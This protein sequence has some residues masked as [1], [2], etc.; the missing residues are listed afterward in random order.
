MQTLL[1][2]QNDSLLKLVDLSEDNRLAQLNSLSEIEK[3][4][5]QN[6]D[7]SEEV[8]KVLS[9][10]NDSIKNGFEK[11]KLA[12]N[13]AKLAKTMEK[14][15]SKESVNKITEAATGRREY[16][17][18]GERIRD[19]VM[20]RDGDK[21]DKDSLR[22]KFT[23][24]KGFAD[25]AGIVKAGSTGLFGDML[26]KREEKQKYIENAI[27]LNPQQK[28]LAQYGGDE[29]KV[30]EYYGKQ[31][32]EVKIGEK[33]LSS[34]QREID[35][36]KQGGLS[37]EE[38]QRTTGGKKLLKEKAS[39]A[40][41]LGK[42]DFRFKGLSKKEEADGADETVKS[43]NVFP[44]SS[45]KDIS[46][47]EAQNENARA[48][49]EQTELLYQ[50]EEN[51]RPSEVKV[52]KQKKDKGDGFNFSPIGL[53]GSALAVT[54]GGIVGAIQGQLKAIKFFTKLLTPT[55]L[56]E[57][58]NKS[59]LNIT[60]KVSKS[61][62]S[63]VAGLSM[64]FDL[65]KAGFVEKMKTF[66][67]TFDDVFNSVKKFFSFSEDS[68]MFKIFST[69]KST[70]T[71]FLDPI[72]DAFTAIKEMGSGKI[73]KSV[74]FLKNVFSGISDFFT[75]LG[76]KLGKFTSLFQATSKIVAKIAYPL[77]VIMAIWDTVKGALAGFEKD[78]IV[79]AI[80]GA[81]KGLFNSLVF[82][83][84]D[85]IKGGISWI[86]GAL[87]FTAVEKFLDSF[88]FQDIFSDFVDVV[89]FIPQQIQNLIMSPI[90]T[91][92]KLGDSL[93]NMFDPVKDI[94]GQMVDAF[95][96]L[97][98]QIVGLIDEY[99]ITP[100][101]DIFKPVTDFF[102]KIKDQVFGF[103]EDF[104]IPEIGFTIPIIGKKV[105]IGP[106]YPFRPEQGVNRVASSTSLN[107]SGSS[108]GEDSS[109]FKQNITSSGKTATRNLK[110]G[111]VTYSD[112][113]TEVLNI[114]EKSIVGK[115]GKATAAFSTT[116]AT[117]DPKTGKASYSNEDD[118]NN[119]I[120]DAP[121]TKGGF[122]EIKKASREGAGSDK[123]KEI[124]REDEAY[125]KLGFFDKRKVDVG[126]AK[127]TELI[128]Q[129]PPTQATTVAKASAVNE[130]TKMDASKPV[131]QGN[132][133]VAP[134]TNISNNTQNQVV[135]LSPRNTDPSLMS[136]L[137]SR[138]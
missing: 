87:G 3:S 117:F 43:S 23:T 88:S 19:K 49:Q 6:K 107:Q 132:T 116:M 12:S 101:A 22:Y 59:F 84:V 34:K 13:M 47:K 77:T 135:K 108:S 98:K 17:G 127:A 78:G 122:R 64:Q 131:S 65:L 129:Q 90:E 51:T 123:I 63:F 53:M 40:T 133:L 26:A 68:R 94:V 115:D 103:L 109:N 18:I 120:Y 24:L 14:S 54:L 60:A 79:G 20:G 82:G 31:F 130:Q 37:D 29:S 15:F 95:L 105:S 85:M 121:L 89:L 27:K 112:D 56:I 83:L 61:I 32:E 75:G 58:L 126:Y 71:K 111:S 138:Y 76:S 44:I 100:L 96:W 9:K 119:P 99:I 104:G 33:Q 73:A 134:T 41:T 16:R 124:I 25:T 62:S 50:I 57:A 8:V 110:D 69:I 36:L 97:P 21:Y 5:E 4:N 92:K 81:I 118:V 74:E 39:L 128:A 67:T 28:N 52:Q 80:G 55:S 45:A 1:K 48:M 70:V 35:T 93:M 72:V 91:L 113:K 86:A 42:T 114:E 11:S 125:Q 38:I 106:F 10:V 2:K 7:N 46:S 136:Y 30:R 102:A 66:G 137:T